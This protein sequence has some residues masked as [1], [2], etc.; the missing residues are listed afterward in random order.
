MVLQIV[1]YKFTV[2]DYHRMVQAG[3]LSEDDRVEL[4]EGEIV[5]MAPIGRRHAGAVNR[6]LDKFIPLQASRRAIISVQNPIHLGEHSE[7]Q[8]DL[9]LLKP[10]SDF[11]AES[12]PS[13]E[14]VLL[15]V[16]VSETSSESDREVKLPLYARFG[17]G[18]VWLVDLAAEA[19]EVFRNP[20]PEGYRKREVLGQG[21]VLSPQAFPEM[22][23]SVDGILR[24][25]G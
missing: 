23:L 16:E 17:I 2:D 24:P 13:P 7:P 3:I 20:S 19:V 22:E 21:K 10:R 1:R 12:H 25:A 14:D 8:P 15:L 4:I 5:T 6:L 9:A 11:Y 18:E